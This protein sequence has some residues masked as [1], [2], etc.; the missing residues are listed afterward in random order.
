MI[1]QLEYVDSYET[2]NVRLE[3]I[4]GLKAVDSLLH[5][6]RFHDYLQ[7]EKYYQGYLATN[8][9]MYALGLARLLYPGQLET[10]DEAE[11][12]GCVMWYSYIKKQFARFFPHFF[13][14]SPVVSGKTVNMLEQINAQIRALTD[15]DITKE[16]AVYDKDCWRAL[17]EL[18]AKARDAEELR[19]KYHN[20]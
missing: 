12:A 16:Q 6:V 19:K 17:T 10:I 15:G 3:S 20:T 11:L 1:R 14:P 8:Q 18:D 9:G 2:M 7:M 4:Q 5:G 13:K